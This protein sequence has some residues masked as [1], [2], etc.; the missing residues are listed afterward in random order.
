MCKTLNN[1]EKRVHFTS[2][3][4]KYILTVSSNITVP[5]GVD[6]A[7]TKLGKLIEQEEGRIA[8]PLRIH[9][10]IMKDATLHSDWLLSF[11]FVKNE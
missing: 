11:I 9:E 3:G 10:L 1:Y 2:K 8:G 7:L 6:D 5:F 4:K